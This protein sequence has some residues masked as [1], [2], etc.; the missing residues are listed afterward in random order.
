MLF[1]WGGHK[2]TIEPIPHFEKIIEKKSDNFLVLTRSGLIMD[3]ALKD[4]DVV[5][6]V[7]IK[8]LLSTEKEKLEIP[9][10]VKNTLIGFKD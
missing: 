8:G 3:K 4:T 10:E 6:H 2:I 7:V 9:Y 1:L 5:Y